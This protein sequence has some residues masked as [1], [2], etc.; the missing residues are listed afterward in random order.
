M[1]FGQR[2]VE[3][4]SKDILTAGNTIA[5]SKYGMVSSWNRPMTG[6]NLRSFVSFCNF[7]AR[8]VPM[9]Q[10]QCKPLRD[11]YMRYRKQSIPE[12]ACSPNLVATFENLKV[13]ITSSPLLA[14]YDSSK[15]F[16]IKTDWSA[17]GMGYIL[18]QPDNSDVSRLALE[19]LFITG[20]CNFDLAE[21]G[22][23]LQPI[24][25]NSRTCT[26]TGRRYHGFVGEIS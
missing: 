7:Y 3:Y 16:F 5:Q 25:F 20:V 12:L 18:M 26:A 6:D 9:F 17:T 11:V 4:V 2:Q 13:A 21:S 24:V 19:K 22:A 14:R 8:F 23:Q 15:H 1:Q 10:I